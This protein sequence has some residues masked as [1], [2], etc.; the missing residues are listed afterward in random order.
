MARSQFGDYLKARRVS[1]GI[2]LREFCLQNGFDA[3]NYS[4]LERGLF[5]VP[6]K[7]EILEKYAAALQLERG[8]AEWLEFFDIASAAKGEIPPDLLEDEQLL[9]KLPMLFRTLRAMP[10]EEGKLE[11]LIDE[12]RKG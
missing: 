6:Q 11:K 3:G 1:L 5:P 8:G 12:L 10:V 9:E 7:R 4:R 2:T